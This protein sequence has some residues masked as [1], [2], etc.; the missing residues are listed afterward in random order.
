MNKY[1]DQFLEQNINYYNYSLLRS[2]LALALL[3]TV[4]FNSFDII[5]LTDTIKILGFFDMKLLWFKIIAI[6]VLLGV[7]LGFYPRITGILQFL[8]TFIFFKTCPFVDGGD[9]LASNI[10]L[11][12]MPL[13]FFDTNKNHWRNKTNAFNGNISKPFFLI[14]TI[15][16]S[17]QIAIVYLH[18]SIGKI[19]VAEWRDGTALWY[20][21][22]HESF[23]AS[24]FI[25]DILQYFL[26]YPM[27][28]Y[29]LNWAVII[30]ELLIAMM[31]FVP[32]DKLIPKVLF[33][34]GIALHLGII[35]FHGIFTFSIVMIGGLIF[36][37]QK[38]IIRNG[39]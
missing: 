5:Y 6:V 34:C 8:I 4:V 12:I 1:I 23:G 13:T 29:A 30:L 11:L 21:F 36:Y 10:T 9:Q 37:F 27:F 31:L 2:I 19:P 32:K 14:T 39:V 35:L 20:W 18:S 38:Q 3:L 33:Y 15:L 17:T 7:I 28:I 22:T 24:Y 26:Q 16:I 25:L